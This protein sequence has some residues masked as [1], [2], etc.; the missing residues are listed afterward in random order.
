MIRSMLRMSSPRQ[1]VFVVA[2]SETDQHPISAEGLKA[3]VDAL[4]AA[5]EFRGLD[6]KDFSM[7]KL[8][9]G[10]KRRKNLQ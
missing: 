9:M 1:H 5:C 7:G 2:F 3:A 4:D 6:S 10:T 8:K